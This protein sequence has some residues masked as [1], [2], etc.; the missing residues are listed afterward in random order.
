MNMCKNSSKIYFVL[1]PIKQSQYKGM[2]CWKCTLYLSFKLKCLDLIYSLIPM[3]QNTLKICPIR[4]F[5]LPL[6]HNKWRSIRSK[7]DPS[8]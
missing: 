6:F 5:I 2:E 7:G 8:L 4:A 1:Q 3:H